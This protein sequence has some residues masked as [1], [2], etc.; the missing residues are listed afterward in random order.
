MYLGIQILTAL[1][2]TTIPYIILYVIAVTLRGHYPVCRRAWGYRQFIRRKFYTRRRMAL[3]EVRSSL[4]FR[5]LGFIGLK[6][7]V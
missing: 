3:Y 4:G 2:A 5:G 6:F 7:R 1:R